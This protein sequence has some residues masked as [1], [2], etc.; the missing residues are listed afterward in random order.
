MTYTEQNCREMP[1]GQSVGPNSEWTPPFY[2]GQH[3]RGLKRG[4]QATADTR[5]TFTDAYIL[6]GGF[7]P[8]VE[9]RFHEGKHA[10]HAAAARKWL[11]RQLKE[12]NAFGEVAG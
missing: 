8:I 12:R 2:G 11:D 6:H 7:T 1:A 10:D 4:W 5:G 9:R 3:R